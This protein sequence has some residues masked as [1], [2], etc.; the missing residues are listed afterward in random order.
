MISSRHEA[1]HQIFRHD[2]GVFARAFRAL[3]LPLPDPIEVT[4]VPTDLTEI[5][6]VE[7]RI[8]TLL[9]IAT[10]EGAFL[11]LV[12]AQGRDDLDK[13]GAWAYY[14]AHL[15]AK[16]KLPP[17]LLV[18]CQD[19]TTAMWAGGELIIGSPYWPSLTVRPLVFGPHNVPVITDAETARDDIPLATLSA[20]TH[21]KRPYIGDILKALAA[22]L[23]TV[24]DEE[25][26]SIFQVLTEM[27]LGKSPAADIWR[28]MMTV[29]LSFFRSETCQRVRAEGKASV[30]LNVLD[31][32]GIAV[33]DE[34]RKRIT[35]CTDGTVLDHWARQAA[36]ATSIAD[37][38]ADRA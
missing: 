27:A 10:E 15:Y 32:R 5:E 36:T 4:L 7:R 17:I 16:Y 13:P 22:A 30:I 35:T 20:I 14:L 24:E 34:A 8:D 6:P 26:S 18:V 37:L 12:E 11:L 23:K 9:R 28:K 3:D 25:D 1:M 33:P 29:D 21:A 38:F 19:R 2:P 31:A